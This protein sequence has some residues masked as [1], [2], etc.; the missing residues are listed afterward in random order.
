MQVNVRLIEDRDWPGIDRIQHEVYAEQLLEDVDV[1]KCK[2]QLSPESCWVLV[3]RQDNVLGYLLAHRWNS[4]V[5]PPPLNT[6]IESAAGSVLFIHDLS[7][8]TAYQCLG[9]SKVLWQA[10]IGFAREETISDWLL[11]SVNHTEKFWMAHGFS[12]LAKVDAQK[13]YGD[14]AKLMIQHFKA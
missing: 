8:S 12:L 11:V 6:K 5:T 2:Q 10:F 1:I 9:L 13:G 3:D 4:L 14:D 7:I